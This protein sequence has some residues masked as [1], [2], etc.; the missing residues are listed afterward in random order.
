M[1]SAIFKGTRSLWKVHGCMRSHSSKLVVCN[2]YQT[3]GSSKICKT[4]SRH[5]STPIIVLHL[6]LNADHRIS[7]QYCVSVCLD[8]PCRPCQSSRQIRQ[9][10]RTSTTQRGLHAG[11]AMQDL[12]C[13]PSWVHWLVLALGNKF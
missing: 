9:T 7:I 2:L 4:N 8:N 10:C 1:E 3:L 11:H 13:L 12:R 5:P 6:H